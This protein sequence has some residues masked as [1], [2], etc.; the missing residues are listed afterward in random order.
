MPFCLL[1]TYLPAWSARAHDFWLQ[2]SDFTPKAGA[3]VG[4]SLHVGQDF[5]GEVLPRIDEW[6]RRFEYHDVSGLHPVP[7]ELGDD[8]AGYLPA[9]RS[10]TLVAYEG[11]RNGVKLEAPKFHAYLRD[12]GLEWVIAERARRGAARPTGRP[13]SGTPGTPRR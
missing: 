4:L 8:P 5:G 12:E 11:E 7:G 9:V 3:R 2:P 1:L 13:A 10:T 6:I